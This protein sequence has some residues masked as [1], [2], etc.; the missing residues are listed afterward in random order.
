MQIDLGRMNLQ[1]RPLPDGYRLLPWQP[2]L[3]EHHANVK[4]ESFCNEIDA[5]V[6]P[7]LAERDGCRMLMKEITRRGNF[8]PASTWLVA[9]SS[10][11][12][13]EIE[14]CGT[15]Q[16]LKIQEKEGSIQNVGVIPRHRGRGLVNALLVAALNGFRDQG[17]ER[18][19]LE[20][21]AQNRDAIQIYLRFGFEII[22]PVFKSIEIYPDR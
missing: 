22:K 5:H 17:L 11:L 19:S 4:F 8:I 7:S 13:T 3:L 20:V 10:P 9:H 12:Q 18:A 15:I 16:G 1:S 2:Y 14:Y 21:T 6:F